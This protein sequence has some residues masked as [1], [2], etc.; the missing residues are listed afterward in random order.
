MNVKS[1]IPDK[2]TLL[3]LLNQNHDDFVVQIQNTLT[4]SFK[5]NQK[6]K[7]YTRVALAIALGPGVFI[8]L[9]TITSGIHL[10]SLLLA[11]CLIF[12]L[13]ILTKKAERINDNFDHSLNALVFQRILRLFAIEHAFTHKHINTEPKL[14]AHLYKTKMFKG[15][16]P[17]PIFNTVMY[18]TKAIPQTQIAQLRINRE[19]HKKNHFVISLVTFIIQ[20]FNSKE[21]IETDT[22][23]HGY[24]LASKRLKVVTSD[25]FITTNASRMQLGKRTLIQKILLQKSSEI[26]ELE[27][28]QF[29]LEFDVVTNNPTEAREILTPNFIADLYDWNEKNKQAVAISFTENQFYCL[30]PYKDMAIHSNIKKLDSKEVR[31]YVE[32][33]AVPIWHLLLLIE[34]IN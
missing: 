20:L 8:F 31:Q 12:C 23:F 33:I 11:T 4:D 2:T 9:Y 16:I 34:D 26:T 3:T 30:L 19:I 10:I 21:K 5:K 29:N 25:I 18:S 27:W 22:L 28:N 7:L 15:E 1:L 14:I 24:F 17:T 13:Y 32:N 6:K